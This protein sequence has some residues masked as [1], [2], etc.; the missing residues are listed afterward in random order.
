VHPI[1]VYFSRYLI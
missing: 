1:L